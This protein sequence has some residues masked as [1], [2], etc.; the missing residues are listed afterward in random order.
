MVAGV[1]LAKEN[2]VVVFF[3][4]ICLVEPRFRRDIYFA[5][6]DGVNTLLFA[7][8]VKINHAVHDAVIGYCKGIKALLLRG[9]G[10]LLYAARAVEKAVFGMNMEMC[11]C[12][13][14]FSCGDGGSF[15]VREGQGELV[16]LPYLF[17][18]FY[19]LSV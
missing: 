9:G 19:Q 8:A 10:D 14:L 11:E 3:K 4:G 1:V 6:D 12:H 16:A 13:N 7:G 2:H 5:A 17:F 15:T 18:A